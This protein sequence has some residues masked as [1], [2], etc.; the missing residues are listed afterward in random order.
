[1]VGVKVLARAHPVM[2][3]GIESPP[4]RGGLRPQLTGNIIEIGQLPMSEEQRRPP[5][6]DGHQAQLGDQFLQRVF[7]DGRVVVELGGPRFVERTLGKL[8]GLNLAPQARRRLEEGDLLRDGKQ[9]IEQPGGEQPPRP[10]AN[11]A[12]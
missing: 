9:L 11:D 4:R 2:S 8:P 12:D 3:A 1:M 7:I 10:T 6:G 5:H